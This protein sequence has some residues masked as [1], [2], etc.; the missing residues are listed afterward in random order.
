MESLEIPITIDSL[1]S[2]IAKLVERVIENSLNRFIY[3]QNFI[4]PHQSGF[5]KGRST[6][7]NLF[8][9][10]K[11]IVKTLA[12]IK[13]AVRYFFKFRKR[14]TKCGIMDFGINLTNLVF[15]V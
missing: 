4:V 7:D 6:H 1:T 13:E 11:K 9:Q 3:L 5:R 2:S 12:K 8:I 14:S 10:Y 15:P